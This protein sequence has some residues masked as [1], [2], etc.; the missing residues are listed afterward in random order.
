[1]SDPGNHYPAHHD[2]IV[3]DAIEANDGN[4]VK[5]TGDGAHAA[6]AIAA[7]AIAAC[8]VAQGA[9]QAHAW[10]ELRIKSRMA[11]HRG[12]AEERDGDYLS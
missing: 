2:A 7:D 10:G 12:I 5:T 1:M 3:R 11:L 4:L 9:L 8:L 6:F